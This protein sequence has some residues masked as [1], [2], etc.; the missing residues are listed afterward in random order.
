MMGRP[1]TRVRSLVG[2]LSLVEGKAIA[3][4]KLQIGNFKFAICN[5]QFAMSN[6]SW[7]SWLR[8]LTTAVLCLAGAAGLSGCSQGLGGGA[9][10]EPTVDVKLD[11]VADVGETQAVV[12]VAGYGSVTGRVIV[13]GAVADLGPFLPAGELKDP[14]V[15]IREQIPDQRVIVGPDGGLA[16]VFVF[17]PRKPAGTKDEAAAPPAEVVMFDQQTC[18]FKPHAVLLRAGQEMRVLNAD[19][20]T[21][22]THTNP[23][24]NASFNSAVRPGEREGIPLVYKRPE[25]SPV[26]VVCD[27]HPW[28]L[29]WHLPLDHPYGALT[30]DDGAF[31]IADVP[32]GK[33]K[34]AVWHEGH[35]LGDYTVE[36]VPD[37]D[38]PLE[39]KITAAELARA[40]GSPRQRTVVLA[41]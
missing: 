16:N 17:L 29:A 3:N 38:T 24:K 26:R 9:S 33:H 15:C 30:A 32:A 10:I 13:E 25:M 41:P 5:E 11:A 22:N 20:I 36:V 27:F 6:L 39:I 19:P 34:F 23:T 14:T 1:A 2:Q 8:V 4:C 28:M 40:E 12:E 35:K 21:H 18:T 37:Q 31:A 7:S